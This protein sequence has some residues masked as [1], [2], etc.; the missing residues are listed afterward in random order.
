MSK[1]AKILAIVG[2]VVIALLALGFLVNWG[3]ALIAALLLVPGGIAVAI[4][5]RHP[6][7]TGNRQM[8]GVSDSRTLLEPFTGRRK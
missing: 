8:F 7:Q 1:L 6:E 5:A 2:V 3:L 4:V